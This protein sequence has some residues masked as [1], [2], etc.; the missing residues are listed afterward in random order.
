MGEDGAAHGGEGPEGPA[1]PARAK[2]NLRLRVFGRDASGY[3]GLETLFLRLELADTVRLREGPPGS[4][5]RLRLEAGE[6]IE[7][8]S[9]PEGPE[10]LCLR[11]AQAYLEASREAGGDAT[12]LVI[13][14]EKRIPAGAGLGGGSA[15]AAA[16]LRLMDR[17][18]GGALSRERM[19]R[20][21][22]ELGSDVPFGLLSSP[23]ALG[24]GRGGRLLPLRPPPARPALVVLPGLGISTPEAYRW[25]DEDR[26]AGADGAS[27][28]SGAGAAGR[29]EVGGEVGDPASRATAL[30]P[31]DEL[32]WWESLAELAAN[33][34]EGPVFR[35]HPEIREA[36][37]LASAGATLALLSG[38]GDAVVGVYPDAGARD[39]AGRRVVEECGFRVVR[40]RTVSSSAELAADRWPL[41]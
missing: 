9:V 8:G 13:E 36:R 30:P 39:R 6:G 5:I 29:G 23:A 11:A 1:L 35:R 21:A 34:F 28:G 38:S 12:D 26:S 22:G 31:P 20:L 3:H 17:R 16:V 19:F 18:A 2:T 10:N 14:L 27:D 41:V 4:G 15:D 33:D 37:D 32:R 40:T 24:W 7:L 25:L